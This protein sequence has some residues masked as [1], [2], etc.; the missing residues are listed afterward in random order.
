MIEA[1][2]IIGVT[3]IL[4]KAYNKCDCKKELPEPD[5]ERTLNDKDLV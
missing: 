2:I 1:A 3:I 5:Y 4:T